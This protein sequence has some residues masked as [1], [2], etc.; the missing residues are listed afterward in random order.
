MHQVFI[1][2]DRRE[3][4]LTLENVRLKKIIGDLTIELKKIEE[5][6]G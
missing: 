1:S 3:K 5:W 2:D 6:Q 4:V